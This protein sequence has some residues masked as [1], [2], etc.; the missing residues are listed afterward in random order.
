[1]FSSMPVIFSMISGIDISY[2][3]IERLY[4]DNEVILAIHNIH[5][6][7]LRKKGVNNSNAAGDGTGYSLTVKKNYE[8]YAKRLK[9][10][11]KES[12]EK[13]DNKGKTKKNKKRLFAYSFNIMDLEPDCT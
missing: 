8:S 3:T 7:I 1:M 4:S 9:D 5:I 13:R 2:K 6:L 11:A 10:L 12:P